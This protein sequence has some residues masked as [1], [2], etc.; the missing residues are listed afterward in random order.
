[1]EDLMFFGDDFEAILDALEEDEAIDD[2]FTTAV[3]DVSI[4][5]SK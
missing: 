5:N 1:M 4:D 2:Q 3:N